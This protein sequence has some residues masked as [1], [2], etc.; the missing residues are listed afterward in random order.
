MVNTVARIKKGSKHFEILVNLDDALKFKKGEA[1]YI[2]PETN[3]IFNDIKKGD[4]ASS[5]DLKIN[6]GTDDIQKIVEKIIKDGEIQTT[7]EHRS[8]EQE[9]RFNQVVDFIAKNA[10]DPRTGNPH[11]VE[12][13]KNTLKKSRINIQNRPVESQINNIVESISMIL[14]IK[15]QLK[16]VKII[17]PAMYTGKAYGVVSP[18][19]KEDKWKDNGDLEVVIEIPNGLI[20]DF[21]DK[22]N[23]ITHGSAITQELKEISAK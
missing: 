7:Q 14:P 4:R 23:L 11:T 5:S 2:T 19:K 6:F 20:M 18:Y 16:R 13:I 17:I 10:L 15:L 21:Y 1:S 8:A 12:K 3:A 22:L 9:A